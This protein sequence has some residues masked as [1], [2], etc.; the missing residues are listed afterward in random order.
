MGRIV[1][2]DGRNHIGSYCGVEGLVEEHCRKL[3]QLDREVD[4]EEDGGD[5]PKGLT[6][7]LKVVVGDTHKDKEVR[8]YMSRDKE[9]DCMDLNL[10]VG[11]EEEG[12]HRDCGLGMK[13]MNRDYPL[14]NTR[15]WLSR[16]IH[17]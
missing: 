8:N 15:L 2:N 5:S 7:R 6:G 1:D 9:R 4:R 11:M 14:V 16:E 10:V 17:K 13:V 3:V 12:T